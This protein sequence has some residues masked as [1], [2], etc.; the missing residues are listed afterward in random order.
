LRITP[1]G[2]VG[3]VVGVGVDLGLQFFLQPALGVAQ[4]RQP[5]PRNRP[6]LPGAAL[7]E[8]PLGIHE[9]P[10]ASRARRQIFRQLVAAPFAM[11]GV[12]FDVDSGGF[13]KH[14]AG[15]L[16]VITGCLLRGVG[17][18]LGAIDRD[19]R[20]VDQAS[21]RAQLEHLAEHT[22]ERVLV[23]LAKPRE[24]RVVGH[25]VGGDHPARDVVLAGPLDRSRGPGP[26]RVGV[27]QHRHHHRRI[28]RR[29]T[30]PIGAIGAI[31]RRQIHPGDHVDDEPREVIL[32]QPLANIRRQQKRLVTIARDEVLPHHRS[33]LNP[34][35]NNTRQH[36]RRPTTSPIRRSFQAKAAAPPAP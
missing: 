21:V 23:T 25:L 33:L 12:L 34:P 24:R 3:L 2:A 10:L 31:E 27:E 18:Q 30:V 6:L 16:I 29:A 7:L 26:A 11:D 32:R 36:Q 8:S 19:H 20:N 15:Y 9:P 17:V 14:V 4:P 5:R 13:G 1:A 22:R 35:D 28:K